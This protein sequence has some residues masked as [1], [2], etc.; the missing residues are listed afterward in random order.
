[1]RPLFQ[2]LFLVFFVAAGLLLSACSDKKEAPAPTTGTVNG[3]ITPADAVT[4]VTATSAATPATT[5]TA[6]ATPNASGAYTFSDLA[7]GTYTLSFAPATGYV[8]P[9]PQRVT[10]T[11]GG[12]T[13]A[14]PVTVAARGGTITGQITP[15]TAIIAVTANNVATSTTLTATPNAS[16]AYTF[17]NVAAGTYTLSFV[18]ATGYAAPAPQSVTV[19]GSGTVVATPVTA[20][21]SGGGGGN[22]FAYTINGVATVANLVSA[23]V[24]SSS[25]LIQSS[26]NSGSR[27]ITLSLDGLPTGPRSYTF[28]GAGSTS[29]IVVSELV[30]TSLLE[31]N[32]TV[33]G[34]QRHGHGGGHQP[35]ARV[36]Y[37]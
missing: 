15:A 10:V 34:G 13:T 18:P 27:T 3:Q 20:T 37:V 28:G 1:M 6:T 2:L 29:E 32:T 33:A 7:A 4:A 30:G 24:F 36:G 14:T 23:N 19:A 21:T 11:A 9:A 35:P 17:T 22:S 5:A 26:S 12:T 31:W 25:L 16:G 8:A